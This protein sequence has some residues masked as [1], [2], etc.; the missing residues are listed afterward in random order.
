MWP[1]P[2]PCWPSLTGRATRWRPGGR[3]RSGDA[4]ARWWRLQPRGL[5]AAKPRHGGGARCATGRPSSGASWPRLAGC[6]TRA[7][8]HGDLVAHHAAAVR[9][10]RP[11]TGC[12]REQYTIGAL[13]HA[14]GY[15]W[16]RGG[17][18]ARPAWSSAGASTRPGH[19]RRSGCRGKKG[20][21]E[22]AYTARGRSGAWRCGAKRG[23]AVPGRAAAGRQLATARPPGTSRTSMSGVAPARS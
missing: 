15:G 9:C 4:V 5:V 1:G 7:G 10:A 13:L 2:G 6:R 11:L 21:I 16:Q 17:A 19:R 20:L 23:R 3:A 12:R 8:W 18:G 14:A 22:R